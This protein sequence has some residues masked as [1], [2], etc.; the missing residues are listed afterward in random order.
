MSAGS[1][2][3]AVEWN[4]DLC[5]SLQLQ[6]TTGAPIDLTGW[7]FHAQVRTAAGVTGTPLVDV[8]Q[9]ID[10][11]VTGV[12]VLD[13]INGRLQLLIKA[14]AWTAASVAPSQA[15]QAFAWELTA[16]TSG[17]LSRA[18]IRGAFFLEPGTVQ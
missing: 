3:L 17:G 18:L 2:D 7:T 12:Y 16:V 14:A 15:R 13:A 11:T 8:T 1:L 9:L 6:D 10:P 4:E 5:F